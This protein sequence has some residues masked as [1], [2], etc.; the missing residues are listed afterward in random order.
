MTQKENIKEKLKVTLKLFFGIPLTII[1]LYFIFSFILTSKNDVFLFLSKFNPVPFA[2]GI[3]FLLLFFLFRSFTWRKL[4]LEEG[5]DIKTNEAIYLLSSS[6]LK[7][8]IPGSIL[9]FLVRI[10]SFKQYKIPSSILVKL[11]FYEG[12]LFALTSLF[13]SIPGAIFLFRNTSI[14]QQISGYFNLIMGSSVIIFIFILLFISTRTWRGKLLNVF[15]AIVSYTDSFLLMFAAWIFFGIGNYLLSVSFVFLD[16][17]SII[18][19]SSFF[20]L[21]WFIGYITIITPLGL[22]VREGIVAYGLSHV[23]SLPFASAI[24]IVLRVFLILAELIFLFISYVFYKF[25][26]F[27]LKVSNQLLALYSAIALYISY[28]TFLSFEKHLNFFTGRFDLG[29]MDQTVWNT[30][31]GRI[32]ELTD[33]DGTQSIL[34]LAIHADFILILISPF[35]LIWSDPRMLLF[36]QSFVIGT[37]AYFVYKIS[38]NILK[39]KNLSLVFAVSYLLNPFVQK[40]NLFDFH[41]VTLATTF[42]LAAFYYTLV[43]KYKHFLLFLF[44]AVLTKE[45][46]YI[47]SFFFGIYLFMK[48][49]N[50]KWLILSFASISAFYLLVSKFIPMVRGSAHFAS[51]YFQNF[52]D[53]PTEI[54]TNII[55]NPG[56]TIYGLL[57][58][59]NMSY[60]F[61]IFL[62]VGF[63]SI[64]SPAIL[65]FMAPDLLLNLLSKN[66]NLRSLTFHYGAIILPFLYISAVYGAHKIIKLNIK[67]LSASSLALY[68]LISSLFATYE[69]GTLPGSKNPSVE[70]YT[71]YLTGRDEIKKVI[72]HIPQDLKVAASNN[73]GA[74]LSQ[75]KDLYTVPYGVKDAD[76]V[77]LLLNDVYAQPSLSS[78]KELAV[79][80]AGN[81]DYSKVYQKGDFIVFSKRSVA[82]KIQASLTF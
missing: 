27:K 56:K 51:E 76:V 78:Q 4:L 49:R 9:S 33:P 8:Y 67:Y 17:N 80:L 6:E 53:S 20:V 41:A 29:N 32:F 82:A 54:I 73:L 18:S 45:N 62:P 50:K 1:S 16:P 35:Y 59:Q 48:T 11:I 58:G 30:I 77:L 31:H 70:V 69:Y 66:E 63:L 43:K 22:G 75:R 36:I 7:R 13:V 57:N 72:D 28:F 3:L 52:G 2:A 65:L 46:V 14:F 19:L 47:V 60:L 81:L 44:L 37:G 23:V 15:K 5:Y 61:K 71:S 10:K 38:E 12:I 68:I 55:L 24:A 34:R 79:K 74:H 40:Q 25:I 39:S 21:S 64:L 42:L 26:D